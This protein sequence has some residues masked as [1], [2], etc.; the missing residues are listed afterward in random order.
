MKVLLTGASG[1]LGKRIESHL[2]SSDISV[3]ALGRVGPNSNVKKYSW[4]LGMSINP[5]VLHDVDCILHLAWSTTDRGNHDYHL[6]VGGSSKIIEA[7]VM[8]G[9]KIINFSSFSAINPISKY[10]EAKKSVEEA[11]PRGLNLRIAKV[12]YPFTFGQRGLKARVWQGLIRVPIPKDVRVP[13]IEIDELLDEIMQFINSDLKSGT[14][15]LPYKE[16]GL[17]SYLLNYHGLRSFMVPKILVGKFFQFCSLTSTRQGK[18]FY[19]RWLSMVS[20]D[21]A[22]RKRIEA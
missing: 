2:L 11:N 20:T 22:L 13:V 4:A 17:D 3:S 6:N 16:Y 1:K 21:Q 5:A 12:E 9:T 15:T 18:L 14:Y 7:A 19:D 10:G 8:S